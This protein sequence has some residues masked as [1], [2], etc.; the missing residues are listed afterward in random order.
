MY[1]LFELTEKELAEQYLTLVKMHDEVAIATQP[2]YS[3]EKLSILYEGLVFSTFTGKF[4]IEPRD[5]KKILNNLDLSKTYSVLSIDLGDNLKGGETIPPIIKGLLAVA[6]RI[7]D[8]LDAVAICWHPAKIVSDFSYF[9]DAVAGYEKNGPFPVLPLIDFITSDEDTIISKGLAFL[10]TQE[11]HFY[12]EGIAA[13]ESMQNVLKISNEIASNGPI[14]G[15]KQF[16]RFD[17]DEPINLQISPT[18]EQVF[19]RVIS[20]FE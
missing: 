17:H 19:A 8:G 7:G 18:G 9:S 5:Y 15:S 3:S 20:K 10:S 13:A 11:L 12:C 4:D 2:A 14:V 16:R 6:R 1:L